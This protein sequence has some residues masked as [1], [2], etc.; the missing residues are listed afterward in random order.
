MEILGHSTYRLTMD[1]YGHGSPERMTAAAKVM[2]QTRDTEA[3]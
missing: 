1:L 3:P 2:D